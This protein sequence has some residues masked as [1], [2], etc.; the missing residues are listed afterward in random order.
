MKTWLKGGLIGLIIG[1]IIYFFPHFFSYQNE[2]INILYLPIYVIALS[3]PDELFFFALFILAPLFYFLIGAIIG[4]IVGKIVG[5][6][7]SNNSN[8]NNPKIV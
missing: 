6:I 1:I 5:K 2:I 7:K 8:S 3:L 4:L